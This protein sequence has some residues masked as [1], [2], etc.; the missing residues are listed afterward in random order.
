M[1]VQAVNDATF[2]GA[3]RAEGVTLADFGAPWCPPCRALEPV[4]EE[5]AGE[6]G[7]RAAVVAVNCDE[8]PKTAADFGVMSLPTVIVF[9][10]GEP[11]EKLGGLRPAT[12]YRSLIE[13]LL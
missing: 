13:K 6:F 2:R 5:L 3:I 1:S 8:S 10:N 9:H 7:N 12:A 4:I 11:V